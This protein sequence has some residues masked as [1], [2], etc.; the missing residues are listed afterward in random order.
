MVLARVKSERLKKPTPSQVSP[1]IVQKVKVIIP[2]GKGYDLF[3]PVDRQKVKLLD[4]WLALQ[5]SNKMW[6]IEVDDIYNP[7]H[8]KGNH[9]VALWILI[10][11]RHIVIW[12]SILNYAFD[13][14]ISKLVEPISVIMP[15]FLHE[16]CLAEDRWKYPYDPY[17][18]E[19]IKVGVPQNVQSG[20]CGVYTMKYIE[21]HALG[22]PFTST[23]C[24]A[25]IV[26]IREKLVAEIFEE[27]SIRGLE[28]NTYNSFDLYD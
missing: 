23:L 11:K 17:T 22:H 6:G 9:W 8:I 3:E 15:Y 24:D 1:F 16:T 7:L 27:T 14:E 28:F 21:C 26:A 10:P 25:N 12:D 20:D 2:K 5:P 4:D 18:H 19:R 13:E